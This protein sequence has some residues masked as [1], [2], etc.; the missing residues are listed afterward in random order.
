[1]SY[2]QKKQISPDTR[3]PVGKKALLCPAHN[4]VTS[5]PAHDLH[6]ALP[7]T[8]SP[9]YLP[10]SGM[11][12]CPARSSVHPSRIPLASCPQHHQKMGWEPTQGRGMGQGQIQG[13]GMGKA[14]G[15]QAAGVSPSVLPN[16]HR[17]HAPMRPSSDARA[18][19]CLGAR[20]MAWGSHCSAPT[21]RLSP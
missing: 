15:Q 9:C 2:G 3:I 18:Q 8:P 4:T 16:G 13:Q 17:L 6:R 11:A 21:P 1:M 5:L 7:A 10:N 19:A 20:Y 12:P 14:Q